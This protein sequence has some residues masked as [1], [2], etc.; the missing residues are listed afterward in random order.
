MNLFKAYNKFQDE[1]ESIYLMG[2]FSDDITM[3]LIELSNIH[4]S[5]FSKLSKRLSF[6]TAESFQNIVRHGYSE[7]ETLEPIKFGM[8]SFTKTKDKLILST[9]NQ[10]TNDSAVKLDKQLIE[11]NLLNSDELRAI[12]LET[13]SNN[14]RTEKG[15]AGVGFISILRKTKGKIDY[16]IDKIDDKISNFY[17]QSNLINSK[18]EPEL[19]SG[20][21]AEEHYNFMED[22]HFLI[23]RKGIFD[24]ST[25]LVMTELLSVKLNLNTDNEYKKILFFVIIELIQNIYNH[26]Y[27]GKKGHEGIFAIKNENDKLSLSVGNFVLTKNVKKIK[28]KFNEV[29]SLDTQGIKKLLRERLLE[30]PVLRDNKISSGI[31]LLEIK[32]LTGAQIGFEFDKVDDKLSY[33]TTTIKNIT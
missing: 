24:H 31:G 16:R 9:A 19:M 13:L 10:I 30:F 20:F 15:G 25:M 1:I 4:N 33:L 5:D 28:E 14:E 12:H 29:N 3:P 18:N 26:G 21:K 23:F 17:F 32:K 27:E 7:T 8:F 6:L 2:R 22:N 11:L